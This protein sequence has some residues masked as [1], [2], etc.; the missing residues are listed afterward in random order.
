MC[1]FKRIELQYDNNFILKIYF[2]QY[3]SE[4]NYLEIKG[5]N[6]NPNLQIWFDDVQSDILIRYNTHTL[7]L[8][9][10]M[11]SILVFFLFSIKMFKLYKVL[12]TAA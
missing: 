4:K 6:F 9:Y 10:C 8:Y 12:G 5:D 2:K 11:L 1:K 3:E 7:F